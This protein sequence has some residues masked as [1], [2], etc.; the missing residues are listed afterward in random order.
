MQLVIVPTKREE[1]DLSISLFR[2]SS[3]Q[4]PCQ[5]WIKAIPQK[6]L[7]ISDSY[8]TCAKLFIV[9]YS[10]YPYQFSENKKNWKS[11]CG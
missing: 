4:V 8:R 5:K 11:T 3:D 7:K 9:I 2:L 1:S 6:N 10:N